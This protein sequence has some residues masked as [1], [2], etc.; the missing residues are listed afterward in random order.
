MRLC[1]GTGRGCSCGP[2]SGLTWEPELRQP[3]VGGWEGVLGR[4]YELMIVA[5]VGHAGM[6]HVL[7][8]AGPTERIGVVFPVHLHA[9]PD[10]A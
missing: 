7:L 4:A 3:G 9:L 10:H 1:W 6:V 5:M 8:A 2:W